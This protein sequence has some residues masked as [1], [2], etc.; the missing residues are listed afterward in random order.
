M[1]D[2]FFNAFLC[3]Q[4]LDHKGCIH[5]VR[6]NRG[7][8]GVERYA[9]KLESLGLLRGRELENEGAVAIAADTLSAGNVDDLVLRVDDA[10]GCELVVDVVRGTRDLW[11]EEDGVGGDGC[12]GQE[13]ERAGQHLDQICAGGFW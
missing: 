7:V 2:E 13:A 5:R 1:S 4:L 8:G 11:R 3:T 12:R 9:I 10:Q 6:G